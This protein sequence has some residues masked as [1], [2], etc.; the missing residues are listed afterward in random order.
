MRDL[1]MSGCLSHR[2]LTQ[3]ECVRGPVQNAAYMLVSCSLWCDGRV[4]THASCTWDW[5]KVDLKGKRASCKNISS[6]TANI[7]FFSQLLW[8]LRLLFTFLVF[9]TASALL[10]SSLNV[11]SSVKRSSWHWRTQGTDVCIEASPVICFR[12]FSFFLRSLGNTTVER[13]DG[14]EV[15]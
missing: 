7:S 15:L 11:P 5:S 14:K 4:C 9:L 3:R 12:N 10:P 13:E 8:C 6:Y 2:V 1:C